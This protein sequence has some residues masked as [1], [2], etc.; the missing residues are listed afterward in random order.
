MPGHV[1]DC[2]E[3]GWTIGDFGAGAEDTPGA[4]NIC[5][6]PPPPP[7]VGTPYKIHEVQGPG[8]SSPVSGEIVEIEGVV[9]GVYQTTPELGQRLGGFMVQ[10]EAADQDADPNTSEGIFVFAPDAVVSPGDVVKVTGEATEF[11]AYT[12]ISPTFVVE[13]TGSAP[14]EP[15]SVS[16]P[17]ADWEIYE[18]MLVQFSHDLYISEFFNFDRFNQVVATTSRQYQGTHLALPGAEANA[19]AAE[20]AANRVTIDDGRTASNP[21]VPLHPDGSIFT[22]D[23]TF[24]G[25]D[26]LVDFTGVVNFSFGR[27][28]V[29]PANP[30]VGAG[31]HVEDNPRPT[32]PEDV[33]GDVKV[34]SFNVLNFF[35]HI[36]NGPDICGPTMNL[37][38]RGADSHEEYDR[39]LAKLLA[40]IRALDADI[41]GFQE[42]ENDILP[43]EMD[44]TRA[45]DPILTIVEELNALDGAGTWAWVGETEHYNDYPVRNEMIYRTAAVTPVGDPVA[46]ADEAFDKVRPGDIEPVGRPPLEQTFRS[47]V[48]KGGGQK[49]SVVVNHFKSK[50]S[51]C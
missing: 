12:E 4:V 48:Q 37:D 3:D 5:D 21:E 31:T 22:L 34:A 44:G 35:T 14:I 26:R 39:Q 45:H 23:N 10:E 36:D 40:G 42:I 15:A 19:I 7:P 17:V 32:S 20:N 50:G 41:I 2:S 49:F 46:Y 27:F 38:C 18:G 43:V 33:G 24:R 6:A 16:L 8:S 9:T 25:G 30:E 51:S 47:N 29:V 11:F 28:S 13:V 1:Y